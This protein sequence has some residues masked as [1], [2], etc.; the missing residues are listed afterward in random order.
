MNDHFAKPVDPRV[1]Y[2]TLL[3]WLPMR[4]LAGAQSSAPGLAAPIPADAR[5]RL[6]TVDEI[7]LDAALRLVGGQ[8]AVLVPMLRRLVTT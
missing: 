3:R 7:D 8:L 4:P 2:A 6:A 5:E 1:L